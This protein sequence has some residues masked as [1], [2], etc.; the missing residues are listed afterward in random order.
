MR[1]RI[2]TQFLAFAI[3][4]LQTSATRIDDCLSRLTDEQLW[5]RA[6]DGQNAVGNLVL[7]LCGNLRQWVIGAIGGA[8]DVRDRAAEFSARDTVN[9]STLRQNMQQT[10]LE[11]LRIL[12][13]LDPQRL[14]ERVNVQIYERSVLEA[15]FTVV[16]HF[17][18]HT[19]QIVFTTK[20]LTHQDLGY[21]A[22]LNQ[23]SDTAAK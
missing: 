18:E 13:H 1:Q 5:W 17:A 11:A 7:H 14:A 8:P 21:S 3:N 15:V 9:I 2:G 4:R 6:G 22:T 20:M 19:G 10:F 23:A 12:E 16:T